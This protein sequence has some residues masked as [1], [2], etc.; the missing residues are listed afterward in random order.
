MCDVC[1]YFD[2]LVLVYLCNV[3]IKLLKE[4]GYGVEYWYVYDEFN[5]FVVGEVYLLFELVDICYYFFSECGL[6]KVL[7]VK[8][9]YFDE[10]NFYSYYKWKFLWCIFWFYIFL[11][12]VVV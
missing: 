1:E 7:K 4:M 9:D 2:Y 11:L 12:L 6:E 5:V 10:F 8:C 3:L